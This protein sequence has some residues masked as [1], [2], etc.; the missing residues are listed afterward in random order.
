M[1]LLFCTALRPPIERDV[2]SANAS[3]FIGG[4]HT[5]NVILLLYFRKNCWNSVVATLC[6]APLVPKVFLF[7]SVVAF[8]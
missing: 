8:S 2:E 7:F 3:P 5:F 6:K 4:R 1:T